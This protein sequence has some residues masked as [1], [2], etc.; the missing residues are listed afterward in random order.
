MSKRSGRNALPSLPPRRT[1]A[2][3]AALVALAAL[4]AL[5][6]RPAAAGPASA[7][8]RARA[9]RAF[10][11][12]RFD[13][14]DAAVGAGTT[15]ADAEPI[16]V[17]DLWWRPRAGYTPPT[18]APDDGS[19]SARRLRWLLTGGRSRAEAYPQPGPD[20]MDPYPLLTAL[21]VERMRREDL[22]ADGLPEAHPLW[23][24]PDEG[25][26]LLWRW[27]LGRAYRGPRFEDYDEA[28]RRAI[29]AQ[30][31]RAQGV[32]ARNRWLAIAGVAG[33]ALACWALGARLRRG[34]STAL[35]DT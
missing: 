4:G 29:L 17:R 22:G 9:E 21:V 24:D 20:E 5:V 6:P 33:L 18:V 10:L 8:A 34:G 7:E 13:D 27:F 23:N 26:R 3:A 11:D 2:V 15:L 35:S 30:H 14:L 16:A 19:L 25:R 31:E 12:G 1:L 32:V 28:E